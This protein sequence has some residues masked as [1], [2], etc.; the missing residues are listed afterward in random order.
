[1]PG[2]WWGCPPYFVAAA[3]LSGAAAVMSWAIAEHR[4]AGTPAPTIA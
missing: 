1:M 3:A 2:S 4:V